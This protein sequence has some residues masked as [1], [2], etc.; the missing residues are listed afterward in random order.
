VTGPDV[1]VRR[2]NPNLSEGRCTDKKGC[3][4]PKK[5]TVE[6]YTQV[7]RGGDIKHRELDD[8]AGPFWYSTRCDEHLQE[9]LAKLT[10]RLGRKLAVLGP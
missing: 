2:F 10:A 7:T 3:T 6:H 9:E 8:E 4:A 1:V 5:W